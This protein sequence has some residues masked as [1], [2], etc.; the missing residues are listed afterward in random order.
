[1]S[2]RRHSFFRLWRV[3]NRIRRPFH[4]SMKSAVETISGFREGGGECTRSLSSAALARMKKRPS[5]PSAIA[6]RGVF[7]ILSGVVATAFAFR[8]S[9]RAERRI[10]VSPNG[11]VP[12]PARCRS[13]CGFALRSNNCAIIV[14]H[15]RPVSL[16]S[17]IL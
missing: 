6:G 7:R 14:R 9:T 8:S 3:V 4:S 16:L 1:M 2:N 12:F 13:C 15:K 11:A 17:F 5:F 10:S